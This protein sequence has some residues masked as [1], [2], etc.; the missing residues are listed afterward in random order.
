MMVRG[1]AGEMAL[2]S[3][4]YYGMPVGQGAAYN[5]CVPAYEGQCF[6]ECASYTGS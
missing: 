3:C 2:T 1:E 5:E 6:L 4:K